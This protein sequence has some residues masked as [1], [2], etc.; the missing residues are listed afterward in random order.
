[1]GRKPIESKLEFLERS[2][3]NLKVD[4]YAHGNQQKTI[5]AAAV[6]L[7]KAIKLL[8]K[9]PGSSQTRRT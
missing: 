9:S 7:G 1:M 3:E 6:K 5:Q 8:A 2:L 4:L